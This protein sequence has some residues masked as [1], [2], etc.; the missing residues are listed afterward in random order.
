LHEVI[1]TKSLYEYYKSFPK[2]DCGYCGNDS[3][4]SMLRR[5]CMGKSDLSDCIFFEKGLLKS[6]D[7]ACAPEGTIYSTGPSVMFVNPCSSSPELMT[8]EVSL[9]RPESPT[10]DYF[11]M[12]TAEKIYGASGRE[13][14]V[15]TSLGLARMEPDG[16]AIMAFSNGR[17]LIRRA[18]TE[19]DAFWHLSRVMRLLWA[20]VN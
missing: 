1:H 17:V 13:L 10:R 4:I 15:S 3:C 2:V 9:S 19:N 16:R 7:F 14:K 12:H 6:E 11:D 20:A 5:H 8:A 18:R